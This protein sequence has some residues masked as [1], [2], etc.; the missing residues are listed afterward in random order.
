MG[1]EKLVCNQCGK[2][3]EELHDSRHI[4]NCKLCYNCYIKEGIHDF[5]LYY[6]RCNDEEDRKNGK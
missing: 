3:T 2:E 1:S 6:R 5:Y 4:E